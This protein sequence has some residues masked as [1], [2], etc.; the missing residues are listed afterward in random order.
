MIIFI[1]DDLEPW[2]R[3]LI[4]IPFIFLIIPIGMIVKKYEYNKALNSKKN[5]NNEIIGYRN[6][7]KE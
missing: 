2:I 1:S 5:K 3:A 7:K 6:Q 4:L